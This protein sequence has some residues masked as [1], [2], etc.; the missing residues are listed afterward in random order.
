MKSRVAIF[1]VSACLS[2]TSSPQASAA[3]HPQ[4]KAGTNQAEL[5]QG[6]A[7][8]EA[9]CQK[10]HSDGK[11]GGCLGPIL[12]GEGSRRSKGFI[13]SRISSDPAKMAEFSRVY[14]HAE[15]MPHI[16]VPAAGARK[17]AAYVASLPATQSGFEVKPHA[18]NSK[19]GGGAPSQTAAADTAKSIAEGRRLVYER[20]CLMCHSFGSFGGQ[21][22]P[23]FDGIGSRHVKDYIAES[24][25]NAELLQGNSGKEYGSR[26]L[27]MPP[28]SFSPREI[29]SIAEYLFS[30][31]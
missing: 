12:A 14:G 31:K 27:V 28:S 4:K 8:F 30:L 19:R 15:L 1:V 6:K 18:K 16:R 11:N 7:L 21:F 26:G 9:T 5:S 23:S 29:D 20:G 13:E 22:A 17:L 25:S 3:P 10:C 2:F 24:I